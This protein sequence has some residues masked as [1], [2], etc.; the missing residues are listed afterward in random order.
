MLPYA[1][2]ML[3]IFLRDRNEVTSDEN[4][5]DCGALII[6]PFLLQMNTRRRRIP[7]DLSSNELSMPCALRSN[8]ERN[9]ASAGDRTHNLRIKLL[10]GGCTQ[11][12]S[13]LPV[14]III[15]R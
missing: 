5:R 6:S 1:M 12:K 9:L 7:Y 10:K 14:S 3:M 11:I 13:F 4:S 2:Q 8:G 15:I